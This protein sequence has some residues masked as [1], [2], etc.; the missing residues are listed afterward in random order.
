MSSPPTARL[1]DDVRRTP[2]GANP[3][4]QAGDA[5]AKAFEERPTAFFVSVL[6][7][8][9]VLWTLLP[10]LFFSNVP[11]DVVEVISWGREWQLGYYKHPPLQ[12]WLTESALVLSGGSVWSIYALSQ[13]AVVLTYLPLFLLGREAAGPKAGLLAVLLF[14]L[15]FYA[16][17]PTPEFNPNVLQMPIWGWAALALWRGSTRPGLRWWLVLGFV[18]ALAIYAKYSAVILFAAL[19][20]TSLAVSECR[21]ACRTIGPYVSVAIALALAVPHLQWLR[22]SGFLPLEYAQHRAGN[23]QGL[24]RATVPIHFFSAQIVDELAPALMLLAGGIATRFQRSMDDGVGFVSEPGLRRFVVWMAAAPLALTLLFSLITGYGLFDM[25]GAPM[26]LWI[27]LAAVLLLKP[28][29]RAGWLVW[30]LCAWACAFVAMPVLLAVFVV[31][32]PAVGVRPMRMAFPGEVLAH[33]LT[34]IWRNTTGTPLRIVAGD[35]WPAGVV[36]TYSPDRPSVFADANMRFSPWIAP[37]RVAAEGVLIVWGEDTPD[38]PPIA[39]YQSLGPFTATGRVSAPYPHAP[40]RFAFLRW[41]ISPPG[42][43]PSPTK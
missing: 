24:N 16:N 4:R 12:A 30:M 25:W 2:A 32:G 23:L 5:L 41:A 6:G 21:R 19:G 10:A 17:I 14:S 39:A 43:R 29:Y 26:L 15:V 42:A 22:A 28:V 27:S 8:Q 18:C 31:W 38:P 33:Q 20:A 36:A 34:V 37:Q 3:L 7:L 11:L 35:V 9:F 13:I 40:A 1:T